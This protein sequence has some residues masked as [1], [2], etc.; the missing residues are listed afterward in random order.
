[1][2]RRV[3]VKAKVTARNGARGELTASSTL[4]VLVEKDV[5]GTPP[6]TKVRGK[7]F[8]ANPKKVRCLISREKTVGKQIVKVG[9][10]GESISP[11]IGG[12]IG[13]GKKTAGHIG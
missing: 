7:G 11:K 8:L 5:R 9:C 1:M 4:L 12:S 13:M 6:D 3:R 2:T 10:M